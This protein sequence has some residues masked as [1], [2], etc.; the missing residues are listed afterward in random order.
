MKTQNSLKSLS[1][2]P[3]SHS[4]DLSVVD[5]VA[6]LPTLAKKVLHKCYSCISSINFLGSKVTIYTVSILFTQ[7][8]NTLSIVHVVELHLACGEH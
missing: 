3:R 1:I 7:Q 2:F 8:I 5:L 4:I 6:G